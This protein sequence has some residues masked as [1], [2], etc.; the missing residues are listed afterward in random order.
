M[1]LPERI[2]AVALDGRERTAEDFAKR[3]GNVNRAALLPVLSELVRTGKLASTSRY[4][5]PITIY[6][7][8]R[9]LT[10][11]KTSAKPGRRA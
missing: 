8:A 9:R 6:R 1:T 7:L 10:A 5:Q 3:L 11:S 2:M 4:G